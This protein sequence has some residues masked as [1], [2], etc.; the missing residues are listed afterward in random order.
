MNG[1]AS[2]YALKTLARYKITGDEF[3]VPSMALHELWYGVAKSQHTARNTANLRKFLTGPMTVLAFSGEDGRFAAEIRAEM[4]RRGTPIGP[5][6]L[7]IAGQALARDL[8]VV[9]RNTREFGRVG[10]LKVED[11]S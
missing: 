5:Y 3:F 4:E 9:T 2:P 10:G 8:V 1:T 6:D 11:W 7:L